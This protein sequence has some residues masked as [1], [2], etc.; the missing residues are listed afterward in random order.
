MVPKP[1]IQG[2]DS[3]NRRLATITTWLM[4]LWALLPAWLEAL[5]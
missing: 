3:T 4:V 1:D 5:F 2:R